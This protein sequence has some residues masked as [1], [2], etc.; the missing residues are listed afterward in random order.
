MNKSTKQGIIGA[1]IIATVGLSS[2]VH[3][4]ETSVSQPQAKT[5][6]TVSN[7]DKISEITKETVDMAKANADELGI[8]LKQSDIFL[9]CG[10]A[11]R[12]EF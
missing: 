8:P 6:M 11:A 4:D 1:A 5:P 2:T 9:P 3:A 7:E 12:C 10:A